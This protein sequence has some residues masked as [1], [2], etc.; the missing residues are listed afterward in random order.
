[1]TFDEAV[2]FVRIVQR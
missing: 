1:M 2:V